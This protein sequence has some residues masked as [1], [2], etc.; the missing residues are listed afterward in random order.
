MHVL[1]SYDVRGKLLN[2]YNYKRGA[3]VD[4][5]VAESDSSFLSAWQTCSHGQIATA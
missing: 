1:L 4:R 2:K 3:N 5:D